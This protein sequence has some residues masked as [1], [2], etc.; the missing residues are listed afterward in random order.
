MLESSIGWTRRRAPLW[1][2]NRSDDTMLPSWRDP[3]LFAGVAI[4]LTVG[5]SAAWVAPPCHQKPL[6]TKQLS[7]QSGWSNLS[8]IHLVGLCPV[9]DVRVSVWLVI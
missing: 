9:I 2:D 1:K 8:V 5:Q 4:A 3:D 6:L 7:S